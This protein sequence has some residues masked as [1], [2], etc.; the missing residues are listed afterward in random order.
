MADDL[1]ALENWVA[2]LLA[3][4]GPA[5]R[6]QL[7]VSVA[8][9]LRRQQAANIR[10]QRAPDGTAWEPRKPPTRN[11]RGAIR[12]KAQAASVGKPMFRKLR[13]PRHLQA[14]GSAQE[15]VVAIAARSQRIARI[16][17]FGLTDTVQ[18]G[19]PSYTYPARELLG[20]GDDGRELVHRLVLEHLK[21]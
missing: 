9:D 4:L 21:L 5:A 20:L 7:A 18:P 14:R 10:A 1:T 15:A 2:P 11:A 12:N 6:R 3:K 13:T 16:H 19:G 17:H 8:R